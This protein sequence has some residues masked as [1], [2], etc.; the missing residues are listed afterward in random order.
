MA[1]ADNSVF[2]SQLVERRHRLESAM[3]SSPETNLGR[4]LAEVDA[5]LAR[6]ED[7]TY[8]ICKTCQEPVEAERLMANPL[9]CYCLAHLT[10]AERDALQRDLDLAMEIQSSLLPS[11]EIATAGF[12]AYYHYQ[13]AGPVSGDYCD[14]IPVRNGAPGLLFLA[15]DVSGKGVAASLLMSNLHA[16]FR[17][18]YSD[19]MPVRDLVARANH[20]FCENTMSS[21]YA[22]LLCGLASDSGHVDIC[23]AGHCPPVLVREA[24][25]ITLSATG[26]PL[27]LFCD[28]E[29]SI[30]RLEMQ[31]EDMLVIYTD[32]L[33]EAQNVDD[34]EYGHERLIKA[35]DGCRGLAPKAVAAACVADLHGFLSGRSLADD[36]TVMV[37]KR[38][39]EGNRAG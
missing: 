7:G 31:P 18:L 20:I 35:L 24:E 23:N 17:A 14:L 33:T 19:G 8:G 4:L 26:L 22:T 37:L 36:L 39:V 3:Q 1:E 27:G 21:F 13:A 5:A 15:G 34:Q 29:Y 11:R 6:M 16:I 10:G 2:R 25:A 9:A 28:A 30:C 38:R 32:G 12:E